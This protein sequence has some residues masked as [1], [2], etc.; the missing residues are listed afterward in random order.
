MWETWLDCHKGCYPVPLVSPLQNEV[1]LFQLPEV[2]VF[3]A[4]CLPGN[5]PWSKRVALGKIT[6]P[7]PG[8]VGTQPQMD[9][10]LQSPADSL[11][12]WGNSSQLQSP[13]CDRPRPLLQRLHHS[14]TSLHQHCYSCSLTYVDP[15]SNYQ[16][17][18][19]LILHFRAVSKG[20]NQ[21]SCLEKKT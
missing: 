3:I 7:S 21:D 14:L 15:R 2:L 9:V 11:L 6:L 5:G 1:L 12:S 8:A 20:A 19:P 16:L 13:S 4:E 18:L 17:T 10:G